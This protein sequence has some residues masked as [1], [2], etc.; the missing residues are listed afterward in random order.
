MFR[1]V[2]Y[3]LNM[4]TLCNLREYYK[5]NNKNNN[6]NLSFQVLSY[7]LSLRKL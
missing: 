2:Q 6:N 5:Y 4:K 3:T 1:Y 7:V